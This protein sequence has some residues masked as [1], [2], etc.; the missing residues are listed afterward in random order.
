MGVDRQLEDSPPLGPAGPPERNPVSQQLRQVLEL[1]ASASQQLARRLGMGHTDLIA[2][3]HLF[4]EGPLGPV[5]LGRRLGISSASATALVD[6]LERRGHAVRRPDPTD[7]RRQSV[8]ATPHAL[9][10]AM[11]AL[12]PML[13]G[14]DRTLEAFSDE[15]RAV[16]TR[17]LAAVAGVFEDFVRGRPEDS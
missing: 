3:E 2:L 6:R 13:H 16:V 5:E 10:E 12:L 9:G 17:Y 15:E 14:V 4:E 8:E 11:G 7:R 1:G